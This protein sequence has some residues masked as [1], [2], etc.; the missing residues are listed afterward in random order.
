MHA[1][2]SEL[3]DFIGYVRPRRIVP[4]VVPFGDSSLAD[5]CARYGVIHMLASSGEDMVVCIML[6]F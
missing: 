3:C 1:S 2:F 5:V 4:C 6:Y